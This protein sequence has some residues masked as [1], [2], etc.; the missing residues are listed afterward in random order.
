MARIGWRRVLAECGGACGD[1]GTFILH[2]VGA[3]TVAGL[4]PFG[5]LGGFGL[6]LIGSDA[7][8]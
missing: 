6:F 3:M 7:F 1:L 2:V 5:V 8:Y 4:A